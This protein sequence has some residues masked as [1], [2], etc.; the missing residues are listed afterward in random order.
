M[1]TVSSPGLCAYQTLHLHAGRDMRCT[2]AYVTCMQCIPRLSCLFIGQWKQQSQAI[3]EGMW[4]D[5][6]RSV[7]HHSS[8]T[9]SRKGGTLGIEGR[10]FARNGHVV[11]D[12]ADVL[13]QGHV[14]NLVPWCNLQAD[15]PCACSRQIMASAFPCLDESKLPRTFQ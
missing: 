11:P 8:G 3:P 5:G 9:N 7:W 2:G 4:Q 13:N 15:V 6:L 1:F 12:V 10:P 14:L